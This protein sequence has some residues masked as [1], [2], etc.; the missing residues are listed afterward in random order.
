MQQKIASHPLISSHL[1]VKLGRG[2]ETESKGASGTGVE[3]RT[4]GRL[5]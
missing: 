1:L 2:G 3:V 5:T 4:S